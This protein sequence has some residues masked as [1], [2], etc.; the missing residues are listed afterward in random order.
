MGFPF[1]LSSFAS[2][3]IPIDQS[4]SKINLESIL[5]SI[6]DFFNRYPFFVAGVVFIWLFVIPATQEYLRK[7][8]DIS[9]LDAF[10]K[11]KDDPNAQLLDIR[12]NKTLRVLGSPNLKIFSKNAVQVE[13]RDGDDDGFAKKVK[14][15][16]GDPANTTICILDK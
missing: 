2:E 15:N 13:F 6:D 1:P 8:K 4:S 12:D 10:K 9:A 5:V 11:L 14:E 3:E 16:F 7:Y